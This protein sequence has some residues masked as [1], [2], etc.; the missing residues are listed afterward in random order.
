MARKTQ[1]ELE[2]E[3]ASNANL[4]LAVAA[5]ASD[6]GSNGAH[7]ALIEKVL[8]RQLAKQEEEES[9]ELRMQQTMAANSASAAA[10]AENEKRAQ[11]AGCS[12][13]N[14]HG[15]TRVGGQVLSE[16]GTAPARIFYTCMGCGMEWRIPRRSEK[17]PIFPTELSPSPREV[18]GAVMSTGINTQLN[19][20]D[21]VPERP[22]G[23]FGAPA[24]QD[25]ASA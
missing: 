16:S 9:A 22:V 8:S 11:Q 12:H 2:K 7:Q 4:T 19:V 6:Q 10:L 1:A 24:S 13:R 25:G 14:E 3:L 18:G 23:N 20:N 17:D 5:G 21:V 15:Q